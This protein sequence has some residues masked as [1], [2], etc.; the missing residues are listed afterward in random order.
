MHMTR[1]AIEYRHLAPDPRSSY[2]QLRIKGRR[3][4]AR[5]IYGQHVNHE[6]PRTIEELAGDFELPIE[7][8]KEAIAYCRSNPPEIEEDFR[9]DQ[10]LAEASG[11]ADPN[12]RLHPRVHPL[13]PPE[14][15]QI[16]RAARS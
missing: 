2:K 15:S 12:Y 7:A 16:K 14:R 10:A 11:T 9:I 1:V 8:V 5:T 3:I 13:S 4:F 6:D